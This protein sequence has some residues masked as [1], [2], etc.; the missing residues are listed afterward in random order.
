MKDYRLAFLTNPQEVNGLVKDI[1]MKLLNRREINELDYNGFEQFIV[2]FCALIMTRNHTVT[3]TSSEGKVVSARSFKNEPVHV[4]LREFFAYLK[5]VF[6][7]RG[8]KLTMF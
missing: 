4:I 5:T 3:T 1:N 7:A 6:I 8:E 2:Q